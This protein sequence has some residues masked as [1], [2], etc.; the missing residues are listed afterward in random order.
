MSDRPTL[1]L[2]HPWGPWATAAGWAYTEGITT[3]MYVAGIEL[4]LPQ[5]ER[6]WNNWRPE[7]SEIVLNYIRKARKGGGIVVTGG[8]S[9]GAR[10]ALIAG[11]Q[12]GNAIVFHSGLWQTSDVRNGADIPVLPIGSRSDSTAKWPI[13]RRIRTDPRGLAE[14]LGVEIHW[15]PGG[16]TWGGAAITDLVVNWIMDLAQKRRTAPCAT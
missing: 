15:H 3:A 1:I 13:P 6:M 2:C 11:R 10:P 16:H 5:S 8:F 7:D 14:H 12:E 9:D 4:V